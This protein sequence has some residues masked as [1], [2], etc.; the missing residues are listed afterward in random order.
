[1]YFTSYI[2]AYSYTLLQLNELKTKYK[3][4]L[5]LTVALDICL[6]QVKF[7]VENH[8]NNASQLCQFIKTFLLAKSYQPDFPLTSDDKEQLSYLIKVIESSP[9]RQIDIE[10]FENPLA[11]RL[12]SE[13]AITLIKNPTPAMMQAVEITS[14]FIIQCLNIP[15]EKI[16]FLLD[17]LISLGPKSSSPIR[18]GCFA[19]TPCVKTVQTILA[20][21]KPSQFAEIM[22]IHYQFFWKIFRDLPIKRDVKNHVVGKFS[23]IIRELCDKEEVFFHDLLPQSR[24]HRGYISDVKFS[25]S[26]LYLAEDGT[27]GRNGPQIKEKYYHCSGLMLANQAQYEKDLPQYP[28]AWGPDCKT[29]SPNLNSQYVRDLND[30]NAVYVAGPSG[31]MA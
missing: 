9:Y 13:W 11:R 23:S 6:D 19:L 29:Q 14:K 31:M 2:E 3:D 21:N 25:H 20:A 15:S 28:V 24:Y 30:Y 26:N 5:K 12:E 27:R 16:P 1:M 17:F 18:F 4:F 10:K 7:A 8:N 22:N